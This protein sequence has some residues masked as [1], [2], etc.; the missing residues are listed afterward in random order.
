MS[1]AKIPHKNDGISCTAQEL[2]Y[3]AK[4]VGRAQIRPKRT[5]AAQTGSKRTVVRGRGMEFF[6]SRPYVV[7]DEMRSIDWR[8][9]ARLNKI[10]TKVFVEERGRPVYCV[11]DFSSSM[12]FGSVNCFKSVL[13][14]RITARLC[15][16]ALNGYDQIGGLVFNDERELVC[17]LGG[18][19]MLAR[20]F[21]MMANLGQKS[22][23][24]TSGR[25]IW[26]LLLSRLHNRLHPG[27][28]VFLISDFNGLTDDCRHL[29]GKLKR[30]ADVFALFVAD[31]LEENWPHIGKVGIFYGGDKVIFDTN[32]Q[33][34]L[35]RYHTLRQ[36]RFNKIAAIFSAQNIPLLRF[37]T[38]DD[39]D[40]ALQ[41]ILVNRR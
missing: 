30:K 26:S 34:L 1:L 31:P 4:K 19:K 25:P 32:D 38:S 6:E 36:E 21:G 37:M 9:S 10:H 17:D 22:P 13:A 2:L 28:T 41:K 20:F 7:G 16:A 29:L 27:S 33:K 23:H 3:E 5:K 24:L 8:V 40:V 18:S 14:A 11:V 35:T 15:G 12:F 39:L